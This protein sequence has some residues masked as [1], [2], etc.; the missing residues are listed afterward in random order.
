M[1]DDPMDGMD[2]EGRL[3]FAA[4]AMFAAVQGEDTPGTFYLQ[5][6]HDKPHRVVY[7]ACKLMEEAADALASK[8]PETKNE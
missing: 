3:R 6:W 7:D 1:T 8:T 4:N 2:L 5:N